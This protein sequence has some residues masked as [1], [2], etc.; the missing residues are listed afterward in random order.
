MYVLVYSRFPSST[1]HLFLNE[2]TSAIISQKIFQ[3]Q[4]WLNTLHPTIFPTVH[5]I[6]PEVKNSENDKLVIAKPFLRYSYR[7]QKGLH[8]L[9]FHKITGQ[10]AICYSHIYSIQHYVIK[11]VSDLQQ[12]C[13]FLWVL[14]FPPQYN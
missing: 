10:C 5:L 9:V 6:E 8:W 4:T 7:P 12:V 2:T 14:R 3:M 1:I 11:F 13:C